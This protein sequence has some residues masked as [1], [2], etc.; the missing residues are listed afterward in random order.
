MLSRSGIQVEAAS[1]ALPI[2]SR[3]F[4]MCFVLLY[5]ISEHIRIYCSPYSIRVPNPVALSINPLYETIRPLSDKF[6]PVLETLISS[7]IVEHQK[8]NV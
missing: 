3:S 5:V 7:K 2:T 6:E 4:V 1:E 8:N